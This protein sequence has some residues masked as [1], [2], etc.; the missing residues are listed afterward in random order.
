[1]PSIVKNAC[2]ISNQHLSVSATENFGVRNRIEMPTS[3]G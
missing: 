3:I 1:M 2:A